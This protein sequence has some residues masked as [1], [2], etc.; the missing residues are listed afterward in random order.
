MKVLWI[1]FSQDLGGI[2]GSGRSLGDVCGAILKDE[3][4]DDDD[5]DDDDNG[6]DGHDREARA[7]WHTLSEAARYP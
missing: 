4:E 7:R 1:L 3:G 5:D 6:D 2:W